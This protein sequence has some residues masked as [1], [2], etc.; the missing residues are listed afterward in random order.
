LLERIV[1]YVVIA[2]AVMMVLGMAGTLS[3][4]FLGWPVDLRNL[5][6][7]DLVSRKAIS[8]EP[9][10]LAPVPFSEFGPVKVVPGSNEEQQARQLENIIFHWI[11]TGAV[12]PTQTNALGFAFQISFDDFYQAFNAQL[13]FDKDEEAIEP[14]AARLV[15][16]VALLETVSEKGEVTFRQVPWFV[17]RHN[18]LETDPL[19]AKRNKLF[20]VM[21]SKGDKLILM[22]KLISLDKSPLIV[23]TAGVACHLR[24]VP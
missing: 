22:A 16:G 13:V 21:P 4:L 20:G 14:L 15:D 11:K 2:V 8:L 23:G 3:S 1:E 17:D 5:V 7:P 12:P 24:I 6:R 19:K 18:G 9:R 10:P